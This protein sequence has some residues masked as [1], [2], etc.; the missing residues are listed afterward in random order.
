MPAPS[1]VPDEFALLHER[2]AG[3]TDPRFAR[4]KVHPR[5]GVL[6]LVVLGLLAGCR[7][8]SAVSR[9]G[10]IHP[11]V[12]GPLGPRRGPSV[13]TLH[14]LLGAVRV[15]EVRPLV[16]AFAGDLVARR[17]A[18]D[19]VREVALDG[20]PLRGT[21]EDGDGAPLHVLR[22]SA[23]HAALALDQ[24]PAAPLQGE[25]TAATAWVRDLAGAFPGLAILTGGALVAAQTLRAAVVAGQ[26]D[27]VPRLKQTNRP[28][29]PT[30]RSSSPTPARPT[31]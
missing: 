10:A 8:L 13:A 4:G 11:E 23:Q 9:Y 19:A 30:P 22:V 2:F 31:A 26:R 12:L 16:R 5:P 14:R 7:S 28:S 27:Y 1:T 25:V 21:H 3:L 15:A 20:K 29:S 18:V 24:A 6:A 17:G